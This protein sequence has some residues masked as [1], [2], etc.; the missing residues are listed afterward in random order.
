MST[1]GEQLIESLLAVLFPPECPCCGTIMTRGEGPMCLLCR[2]TLPETTH[3]L[4]PTANDLIDKLQGRVFIE[5]TAAYFTYRRDSKHSA[6]IHDMKYHGRPVIGRRLGE[7]FGRKL[8]AAG[9]FNGIDAITPVPL[10]FWR[11]CRRGYNQAAWF[12]RG[13]AAETGLPVVD[14]LRA[15]HHTSQT[16]LSADERRRALSGVFTAIAGATSGIG[17]ILIVDDICTTGATLYACAEALKAA[18][19]D[20]RISAACIASTSLI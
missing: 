20:L 17:H 16:R 19:P 12:A 1:T 15:G 13:L 3:H 18:R 6:L 8:A 2:A 7:E 11:H 4:S 5:R 10:N 14:T 9:F